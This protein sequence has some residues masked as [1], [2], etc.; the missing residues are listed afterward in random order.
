MACGMEEVKLATIH[1]DARRRLP[2]DVQSQEMASFTMDIADKLGTGA[3][4]VVYGLRLVDADSGDTEQSRPLAA[5]FLVHRD[6]CRDRHELPREAKMLML[7]SGN[8]YILKSFGLFEVDLDAQPK[9]R[10]FFAMTSSHKAP[11]TA[12]VETPPGRGFFLLE[13]LCCCTLHDLVEHVSFKESEAAF[14]L[15]SV[16]CG[17]MHLHALGIVHRDI[18]TANIMVSDGGLRVILGDFDLA[19]CLPDGSAE[20]AW[21]CGTAGYLAPEVY[22]SHK[23]S[24]AT[25]LFALGVVLYILLTKS[26]P[27]LHETPLLTELATRDGRLSIEPETL[28]MFRSHEAC[29]LLLWLLEPRPEHRPEALEA[30]ESE[31]LCIREPESEGVRALVRQWSRPDSLEQNLATSETKNP[32]ARNTHSVAHSSI[33]EQLRRTFT[34]PSS[35]LTRSSK[36]QARKERDSR[37]FRTTFASSARSASRQKATTECKRG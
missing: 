30:L 12:I 15:H 7:A 21:N 2:S 26:Q 22:G 16:L 27:F 14:A 23:G 31:W 8:R 3:C 4:S 32:D 29:D 20:M 19:A 25:D 37:I 13:E 11:K 10:G 24:K 34:S 28:Q 17:L 33:K 1:F 36:K 35:F 5:K 18:K 9:L 6:G